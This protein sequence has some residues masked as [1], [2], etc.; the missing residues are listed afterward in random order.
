[1]SFNRNCCCRNTVPRCCG[2]VVN[3][4][5]FCPRL[6]SYVIR[7]PRGAV[8]AQGPQGPR[9]LAGPNALLN[10]GSFST[11]N[12]TVIGSNSDIPLNTTV[13][14]N[15]TAIANTVGAAAITLAAGSYLINWSLNTEIPA[16][17]V[18]SA[19]LT[20]G[21]ALNT[22]SLSTVTGNA[23]DIVSLYGNI[24]LTVGAS[25]VITLRNTSAAT[26]TFENVSISIAKIA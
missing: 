4:P 22:N 13:S 11:P 19:G 1:M 20:V 15:G 23:G 21:G 6:Q 12:E 2:A 9:G 26:T 18:V 8:G 25:T 5:F 7:G 17:G 3:E 16:G 10:F 14:L 24:I